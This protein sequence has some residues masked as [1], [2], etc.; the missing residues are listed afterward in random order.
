MASPYTVSAGNSAD[1]A[2]GKA[3]LELRHL[4]GVMKRDVSATVAGMKSARALLLAALAVLLLPA[5]RIGGSSVAGP[6]MCSW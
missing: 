6:A 3:A 5:V 4:L 2:L 1:P